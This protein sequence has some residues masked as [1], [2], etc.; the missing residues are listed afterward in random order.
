[1]SSLPPFFF[2]RLA[3]LN[4]DAAPPAEPQARPTFNPSYDSGG[5]D[6][7]QG[8][9]MS[10]VTYTTEHSASSTTEDSLLRDTSGTGFAVYPG[11]APR[12]PSS[13]A[14]STV[15]E[16]TSGSF[17]DRDDFLA[18]ARSHLSLGSSETCTYARAKI[19][20]YKVTNVSSLAGA[21]SE[22][23]PASKK[24][25]RMVGVNGA[26]QMREGWVYV[27]TSAT[28]DGETVRIVHQI[29]PGD[30][31][32]PPDGEVTLEAYSN[33]N[34]WDLAGLITAKATVNGRYD[35]CRCTISTVSSQGA[36]DSASDPSDPATPSAGVTAWT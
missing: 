20:R 35:V 31:I 11:H 15:A 34:D 30:L 18:N 10:G 21:V 28:V 9:D 2:T 27:E 12:A 3:F 6:V 36:L 14:P 4:L 7:W 23:S 25:S 29:Y 26:S 5:V 32:L 17:T 19:K 8:S 24:I 16:A 13:S 1:M 22:V 33:P